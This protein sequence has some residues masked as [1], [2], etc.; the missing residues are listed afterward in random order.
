[1]PLPSTAGAENSGQAYFLTLNYMIAA[2]GA[3]AA[4]TKRKYI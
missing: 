2:S 1:M 4:D 3:G